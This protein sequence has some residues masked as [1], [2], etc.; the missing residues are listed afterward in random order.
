MFGILCKY[1]I[2]NNN[3][4]LRDYCMQATNDSIR[5][6]TE[7]YSEDKKIQKISI[8]NPLTVSA[9]NPPDPGSNIGIVLSIILFLSSSTFIYNYYK[10][11]VK[12]LFSSN[13]Y[14][15]ASTN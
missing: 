10:G 6:I 11:S 8:I 3:R 14:I 12:N 2:Q 5:R 13:K 15:D 1:R 7:K 9:S 4:K